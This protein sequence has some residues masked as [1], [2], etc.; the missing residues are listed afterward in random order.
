MR[1]VNTVGEKSR[2]R[3]QE[4]QQNSEEHPTLSFFSGSKYYDWAIYILTGYT[5][6][7]AER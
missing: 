3:E 6:R 5:E 2:V 7:R 1:D 4:E